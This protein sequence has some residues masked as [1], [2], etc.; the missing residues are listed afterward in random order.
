MWRFFIR[1]L[2][3]NQFQQL[4]KQEL[5]YPG[6][7][8]ITCSCKNKLLLLGSISFSSA[9]NKIFVIVASVEI[10]VMLWFGIFINGLFALA[11]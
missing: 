4:S 11:L 1:A 10:S 2:F 5:G 8:L 6:A 3:R 9:S 7:E